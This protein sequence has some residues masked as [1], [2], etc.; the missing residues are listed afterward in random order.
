MKSKIKKKVSVTHLPKFFPSRFFLISSLSPF[1]PSLLLALALSHIHTL[2]F[3]H[4][5][6]LI[7]FWSPEHFSLFILFWSPEHFS[8]PR[9]I[10]LPETR[11]SYSDPR[12]T[13]LFPETHLSLL[14]FEVQK[15]LWKKF[16]RPRFELMTLGTTV[17]CLIHYTTMTW[18]EMSEKTLTASSLAILFW[19]ASLSRR[20]SR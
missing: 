3:S 11:L 9:N 7:L 5:L 2:S 8:L 10:S 12:N 19:H 4:T 14:H 6:S 17:R 1:P 16:P 15:L 18:W 13:S 20:T